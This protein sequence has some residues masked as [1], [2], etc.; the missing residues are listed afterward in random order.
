LTV[1]DDEHIRSLEAR[2]VESEADR[3]RLA[4][5]LEAWY[6]TRS[7]RWL[8]PAR[9]VFHRLRLVLLV[10]TRRRDRLTGVLVPKSAAEG[11]IRYGLELPKPG[12]L[13]EPDLLLDVGGWAVADEP[14]ARL[15]IWVDG[16]E[17]AQARLG[18]PRP[19]VG[20]RLD[21][22]HAGVSGFSALVDLE[23]CD[24]ETTIE[25]KA[26][27]L[28]GARHDIAS[29]PVVVPIAPEAVEEPAQRLEPV[30]RPQGDLR[31][32]VFT[33]HLG[34]GGGQ[35]YLHE[36]LRLLSRE[37]GFSAALAAP[38]DGALR[39]P[40]E[41]LG[42]PVRLTGDHPVETIARYE[43][44]MRDLLEWARPGGFNAVLV[45][46]LACF[47]GV[48]LASRLGVPAVWAIHD[49]LTLPAFWRAAYGS[50]AMIDR[51][52]RERVRASLRSAAAVVFEADATRDLLV[53][54]GDPRRFVTLRY[55]I[56]VERIDS[57]ALSR[58]EARRRLGL[59]P[60]APV[61]LCLG[62]IEPRKGQVPLV[63]AFA[64]VDAPDALLVLVGARRDRYTDA[65]QRYVRKAGLEGRVRLVDVTPEI[66]LWYR[67]AD[68]LVIASDVE[69]MPRTALEAMAF[70]LPVIATRVFGLPE[71]IDDGVTG[72]LCEPHDVASLAGALRRFLQ[73]PAGE[74]EAVG[75]AAARLVRERHDS[76]GYAHAY[77]A[78]L[79]SLVADPAA[80]PGDVLGGAVRVSAGA[81]VEHADEAPLQRVEP[82]DSESHA[83]P[84]DGSA[85]ENEPA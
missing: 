1:P 69:S 61:L 10:A 40:T 3:T 44:R 28:S 41:E 79:R 48:D 43:E 60:D 18:L 24:G 19:E 42:I 37:P 29:V 68:A 30:A 23:G 55:G 33:H 15:E 11:A 9:Y 64:S 31:V 46:T 85:G 56:D 38:A 12:H 27:T 52:V 51:A 36:L 47:P 5:E 77:G 73:T 6:A 71:L 65:L 35:L 67:A 59:P 4:A 63:Q 50:A 74:R 81:G 13:V 76:R 66:E 78:L 14:V 49:S 83:D 17:R 34:L 22:P 80:L 20:A 8:R 39:G 26:E 70:G 62:T 25:L 7:F 75:A 32:L 21:P 57:F 53:P 2:L 72:W 45:N 16:V 82:A 54:Y 84:V 58:E